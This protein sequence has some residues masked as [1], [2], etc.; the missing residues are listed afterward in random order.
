MKENE[1]F[2]EITTESLTFSMCLY[3]IFHILQQFY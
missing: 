1:I 3:V 2:Y